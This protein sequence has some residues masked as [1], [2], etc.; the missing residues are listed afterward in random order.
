MPVLRA[1]LLLPHSPRRVRPGD[2]RGQTE[3]HPR[4][5]EGEKVN[6][7]K[8]EIYSDA[9]TF[10]NECGV[11]LSRLKPLHDHDVIYVRRAFRSA[12]D[13]LYQNHYRSL[14][15]FKTETM[16]L[17]LNNSIHALKMIRNKFFAEA[18]ETLKSKVFRVR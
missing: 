16:N 6:Q 17:K 4:S 3:S 8:E 2:V 11:L 12:V 1:V 10:E 9:H 18:N 7:S 5:D 14:Q 15:R 13:A